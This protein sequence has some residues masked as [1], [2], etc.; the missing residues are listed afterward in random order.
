LALSTPIVAARPAIAKDIAVSFV[1]EIMPGQTDSAGLF[2]PVGG[3]LSNQLF[4]AS[5]SYNPNDF[6]CGGSICSSYTIGAMTTSVTING[7]TQTLVTG[8]TAG[9]EFDSESPYYFA[10]FLNQ[11]PNPLLEIDYQTSS[12]G[13]LLK[14]MN[15]KDGGEVELMIYPNNVS[16]SGDLLLGTGNLTILFNGVNTAQLKQP[17]PVVVGQSIALANDLANDG[18]SQSWSPAGSPIGNYQLMPNT[19]PPCF[20]IVNPPAG[21]STIT[22]PDLTQESATFYWTTQGTYDVDYQVQLPNGT[23]V[24]KT[25]QFSVGGPTDVTVQTDLGSVETFDDLTKGWLLYCGV[26]ESG[27]NCIKFEA[28]ASIPKYDGTNKGRF[29]WVQLIDTAVT[30]LISTSGKKEICSPGTGLDNT[31]PYKPPH[32]S[33]YSKITVDSPDHVLPDGD[34][35]VAETFA[36][37][38]YLEWDPNMPNSIPV[39]LGSTS[40]SWAGVADL[41]GNAWFLYSSTGPTASAFQQNTTYPTWMSV[42]TNTSQKCQK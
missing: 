21:C 36:A 29:E 27:T 9:I 31:Y 6:I 2:G 8:T 33:E 13:T 5:I 42:A 16:N 37:Q 41:E 18:Q 10:E 30:T 35:Q 28:D 1:G 19:A 12:L 11:G 40:W 24:G 26:P 15:P 20:Q 14:P 38:M 25:L 34:E 3:D 23:L 17:I 22:Q 39:V 7:I 32:Y 4:T